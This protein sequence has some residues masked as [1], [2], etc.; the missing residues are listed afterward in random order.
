MHT[1]QQEIAGIAEFVGDCAVRV[2]V[3]PRL[4]EGGSRKHTNRMTHICK[5][6]VARRVSAQRQHRQ[7]ATECAQSNGIAARP[8]HGGAP[9]SAAAKGTHGVQPHAQVEEVLRGQQARVGSGQSAGADLGGWGEAAR[10]RKVDSRRQGS[11]LAQSCRL[12]GSH[13]ECA[14][15]GARLRRRAAH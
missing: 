4:H 7:G 10:G 3:P 13:A 5:T 11:S 2:R 1:Q 9:R 6:Q 15:L 14:W 8:F 12:H